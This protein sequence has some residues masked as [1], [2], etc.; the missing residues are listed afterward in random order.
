MNTPRLQAQPG[1]LVWPSLKAPLQVLDGPHAEGNRGNQ[2]AERE[3]ED[4]S[5]ATVQGRPDAVPHLLGVPPPGPRAL[6]AA[7]AR[8]LLLEVHAGALGAVV[9]VPAVLADP[10]SLP[11]LGRL[12]L[13]LGLLG[14]G[15]LVTEDGE[16]RG[17]GR[18]AG[19]GGTDDGAGGRGG[20]ER[21][22]R[23]G[24]EADGRE[25]GDD[26]LHVVRSMMVAIAAGVEG[27]DEE[28]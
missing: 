6:R 26:A 2:S 16:G 13:L 15:L 23:G 7:E 28:K 25:D 11:E 10:L 1:K 27:T 21:Q 8:P 24:E 3:E 18:G 9:N 5:V 22:G 12:G 17:N 19:R 4:G 14:L 20:G